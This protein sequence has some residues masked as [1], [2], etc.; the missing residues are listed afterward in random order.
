MGTMKNTLNAPHLVK[1]YGSVRALAD[2]SITVEGG[3]S[4]AIMGPDRP[5]RLH[6]VGCVQCVLHGSH[7]TLF[8][9][10]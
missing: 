10:L 1:T 7:S 9:Q 4:V 6:E 3:E 8:G 2:V 5:V